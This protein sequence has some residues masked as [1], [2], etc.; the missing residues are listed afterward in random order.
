MGIGMRELIV[1]LLV[2]LLVFGAKKLRTIGEDARL[3]EQDTGAQVLFVGFPLLQLPPRKGGARVLA[4]IAFIPVSLS[5]R[6]G[7]RTTVELEAI[8]NGVSPR[9]E[10]VLP[11]VRSITATPIR[12]F[13][14]SAAL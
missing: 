7:A 9:T 1:I 14:E 8:G 3:Y 11:L 2:V 12:P 10:T 13:E 4:P 5:S 6:A